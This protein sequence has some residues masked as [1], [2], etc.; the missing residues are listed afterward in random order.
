[1]LAQGVGG[2]AVCGR[3]D[4]AHVREALDQGGFG[5]GGAQRFVEALDDGLGRASRGVE[6]VPYGKLEAGL[7]GL[8]EGGHIGQGGQA[9][10]RGDGVALEHARLYVRAG[11]HGLVADD[12]D[13]A[14]HQ[15]LQGRTRATVGHQ[16]GLG[17]GGLQQQHGAQVGG[18]AYAG[19]REAHFARLGLHVGDEVRQRGGRKAFAAH[20]DHGHVAGQRDGFQVA[21]HIESELAVERGCRGNAH[22][23]QQQGV[24]V[25]LGACDAA[26]ADGAT[27]AAQV[28]DD[29]LLAQVAR[30]GLGQHAGQHVGG[31]SGR[32]GNDDGDGLVGEGLGGKAGCCQRGGEK[33]LGE[34]IADEGAHGFVS[35]R[36]VQGPPALCGRLSVACLVA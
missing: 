23:V 2:E 21:P 28:L 9:F 4:D 8:R 30:H 6:A 36:R 7:A 18:G 13:I 10:A 14:C 3:D 16:G 32:V 22:V 33:G 29:D 11:G 12:I 25:G 24:A 31:A 1:M 35:W 34:G 20:Q 19:M 26:G 15:V 5:Q 27:G 17:G